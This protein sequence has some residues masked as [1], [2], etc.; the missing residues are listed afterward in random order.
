MAFAPPVVSTQTNL[1]NRV[2]HP[3]GN[4]SDT[5]LQT[6]ALTFLDETVKEMNASLFDFMKTRQTSL[7][8][9]AGTR[10]VTLE[11]AFYR[12]SAAY[13]IKTSDSSIRSPLVYMPYAQFA[14]EQQPEIFGNTSGHPIVYSCFN[15][16]LGILRLSPVPDSDAATNYTL[17][18]EYYKRIPL[19]SSTVAGSSIDVPPEVETPLVF[20]AQKRMAIHINGASDPDVASFDALEQRALDRLKNMDRR[21]PDEQARFKVVDSRFAARLDRGSVYIKVR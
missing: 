20:G 16:H 12:E 21:H 9:V 7:A 2:L 17:T 4:I 6:L 10:E 18:I 1:V 14:R 11:N 3:F 8:M 15:E 13:L 19:I 5:E